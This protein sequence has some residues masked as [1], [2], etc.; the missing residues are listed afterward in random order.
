M[1]ERRDARYPFSGQQP[2]Y[3]VHPQL[4][5]NQYLQQYQEPFQYSAPVQRPPAYEQPYVDPY[6]SYQQPVHQQIQPF[7]IT[8]YPNPYPSPRPNLHQPSQFQ[9]FLSQFKKKNGQLDFSKMMD[10][11]GLMMNTVNQMGTLAKSFM[12][13]FK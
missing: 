9:G 1:E 10:T 3:P 11:A 2:Y 7:H 5:T 13:F 6:S 4:D 12:G 8:P